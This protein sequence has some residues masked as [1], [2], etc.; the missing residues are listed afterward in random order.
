MASILLA[1]PACKKRVSSSAH[2]C[3]NCGQPLSDQWEEEGRRKA[4]HK[5]IGCAAA[6]LVVFGG[7]ALLV[8]AGPKMTPEDRRALECN[9]KGASGAAIWSR[10]LITEKLRSPSTAS[11]PGDEVS[12]WKGGCVFVVVGS[13][14]SQNGFGAVVRTSYTA[15]ITYSPEADAWRLTDVKFQGR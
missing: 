7:I 4:E 10:T 13:V 11:F 5:K 9:T 14:D 8:L 3:P 12:A 1:C 15:E 2:S 6:V